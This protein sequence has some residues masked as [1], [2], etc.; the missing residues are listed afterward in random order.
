M[1]LFIAVN[2]IPAGTRGYSD[3]C[4]IRLAKP[5]YCPTNMAVSNLTVLYEVEVSGNIILLSDVKLIREHKWNLHYKKDG[6][7][8]KFVGTIISESYA[9]L[10]LMVL[11]FGD[12]FNYMPW[13]T[14]LGWLH[15]WIILLSSL[16]TFP[17]SRCHWKQQVMLSAAIVFTLTVSTPISGSRWW[18]EDTPPIWARCQLAIDIAIDNDFRL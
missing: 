1:L 16:V 10:N 17:F 6:R 2:K 8:S 12:V 9:Q 5:L 7:E 13:S 3:D 4:M 14:K 11:R 15:R 18:S